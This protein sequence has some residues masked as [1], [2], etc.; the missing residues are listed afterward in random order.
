MAS[1]F[2]PAVF[3]PI[4]RNDTED[5]QS[6]NTKFLIYTNSILPISTLLDHWY[7]YAVFGIGAAFF[8]APL[9]RWII[10]GLAAQVR[11]SK[12]RK[13]AEN[14]GL[15]DPRPKALRSPSERP[16]ATTFASPI[17][18]FG[19]FL[20]GNIASFLDTDYDIHIVDFGTCMAGLPQTSILR[21]NYDALESRPRRIWG[22]IGG[23]DWSA[24]ES[25][26][27]SILQMINTLKDITVAK[28]L[29]GLVIS[30]LIDVESRL[31][32]ILEHLLRCG[33]P[34]IL[35]D[36]S[37]D[38][39]KTIDPTLLQGIIFKNASILPTGARRDFFQA[40]KL[41]SSLGKYQSHRAK[42]NSFFVGFLD[43]WKSRP[44]PAVIRRGYKFAQFH[45]AV[46]SHT[47]E[48]EMGWNG[49]NAGNC[50]SAFDW[51]KRA[52]IIQVG[53]SC[54]LRTAI[55]QANIHQGSKGV[56]E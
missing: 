55:Q 10:G 41:R 27:P 22:L 1:F 17:K 50:L 46:F 5:V 3:D 12:R 23:L 33:I 8:C 51:I 31:C 32:E 36:D 42:E 11:T 38:P 43:R 48:N 30:S 53:Q 45:G 4:F 9:I 35:L 25:T 56:D 20:S 26:E 14:T 6:E 2:Q 34:C 13:L 54:N 49:D 15:A 28:G 52:D 24:L 19:F 40:A 7:Q 44:L 16:P 21:A 29:S 39:V 37:S 18:S 47:A